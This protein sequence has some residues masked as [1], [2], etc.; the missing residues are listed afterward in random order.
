VTVILVL[1]LCGPTVSSRTR[2]EDT[3]VEVRIILGLSLLWPTVSYWTFGDRKHLVWVTVILALS[4]LCPIG[5]PTKLCP[6]F[7]VPMSVFRAHHNLPHSSRKY[8]PPKHPWISIR[9]SSIASSKTAPIVATTVGTSELTQLY[10]VFISLFCRF[11]IIAHSF[12]FI[13]C[14]WRVLKIRKQSKMQALSLQ[15]ICALSHDLPHC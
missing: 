2:R 6:P 1:S 5:F 10:N 15:K 13:Y 12:Y 9:P 7:P 14:F 4:S 8:L 11:L 3:A